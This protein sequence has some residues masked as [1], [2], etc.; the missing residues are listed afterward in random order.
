MRQYQNKK[1]NLE[2]NIVHSA[3]PKR[4][5]GVPVDIYTKLGNGYFIPNSM[6]IPTFRKLY[7]E[8]EQK[9]AQSGFIDIEYRTYNHTGKVL[10]ILKGEN[11]FPLPHKADQ[12]DYFRYAR[13]F[14]RVA[15]WNRLFIK[16]PALYKY[17]FYAH[18]EGA[19]FRDIMRLIRGEP[20]KYKRLK[21]RKPMKR[22]RMQ[23]S[24]YKI[25][26][27][28]TEANKVF[29]AWVEKKY[30]LKL[31]NTYMHAYMSEISKRKTGKTRKKKAV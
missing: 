28:F 24:V 26:G 11:A 2:T 10:P 27:L 1:L 31:Q 30:G 21:L 23:C 3:L 5:K 8:W 15:N 12:E 17:I 22:I 25:H 14:Y 7:A 18:S 29:L 19:S 6:P 9:L 20:V 13:R 16:Y 4:R